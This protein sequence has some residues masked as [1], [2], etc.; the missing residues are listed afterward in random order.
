M[1]PL[2]DGTSARFEVT[3]ASNALRVAASGCG[4]PCGHNVSNP[5]GPGRTTAALRTNACAAMSTAAHSR[6]T[7]PPGLPGQVPVDIENEVVVLLAKI[8]DVERVG[9]RGNWL[10]QALRPQTSGIPAG[11]ADDSRAQ[12][13]WLCGVP[14]GSRESVLSDSASDRATRAEMRSG[15]PG[16]VEIASDVKYAIS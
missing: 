7:G 8:H 3:V 10:R 4:S 14:A 11:P 2:A 6:A 12:H 13:E 16:V 15:T 5:S 1:L 9:D